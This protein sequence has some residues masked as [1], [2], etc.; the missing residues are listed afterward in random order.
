MANLCISYNLCKLYYHIKITHT[1]GY[2][3]ILARLRQ[4]IFYFRQ[5][6]FT[7]L[8]ILIVEI[9]FVILNSNDVANIVFTQVVIDVTLFCT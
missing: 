7:L 6:N 5:N 1:K 3:R 8:C 4:F 2:K 9:R